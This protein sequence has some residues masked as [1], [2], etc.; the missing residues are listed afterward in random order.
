MEADDVANLGRV[1]G[2]PGRERSR[3]VGVWCKDPNRRDED[4]TMM[5]M[6]AT[7]TNLMKTAMMAIAAWGT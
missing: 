3:L 1:R 6:A 5:T 2:Q 7:T 4:A